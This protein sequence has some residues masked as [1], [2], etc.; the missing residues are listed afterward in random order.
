[1]WLMLVLTI[2]SSVIKPEVFRAI[3]EKATELVHAQRLDGETDKQFNDRRRDMVVAF[4]KAK[5]PKART[6]LI[7]AVLGLLV[8]RLSPK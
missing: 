8:Y 3:E 5:W 6:A 7:E 4:I 1:M 2:L